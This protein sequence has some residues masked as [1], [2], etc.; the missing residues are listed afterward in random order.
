MFCKKL[1][2]VA[3]AAGLLSGCGIKA[4]LEEPSPERVAQMRE[5]LIKNRPENW[6]E[7]AENAIKRR[8]DDPDGV[9]FRDGYIYP[10]LVHSQ[11]IFDGKIYPCWIIR[12]DANARDFAGGYGG[13]REWVTI[14]D[15]RTGGAYAL[16]AR[17]SLFKVT[18]LPFPG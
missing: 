17:T 10:A 18:I 13:F 14:Y 16:K 11:N 4:I 1:A 9:Q 3:L 2:I 12:M 6:Q 7:I 5:Q 15:P 8:L